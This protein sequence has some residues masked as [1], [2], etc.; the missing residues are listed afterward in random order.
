MNGPVSSVL[1]VDDDE[2]QLSMLSEMIG[3]FG[4]SVEAAV[5]GQDALEKLAA[6]Q[7]GVIVTDLV[8]PRMDGFQFLKTL[9]DND[10]STPAIVLTAFGNVTHAVSVVHDLGAF[11]FLE[12]PVQPA[13]LGALLDRAI[14]YNAALKEKE[15]LQRELSQQG[16]LGELVGSSES[17]RQVYTLIQ[18]V[19]P[20]HASVLITGE[21]GTGKEIAARTIH[22]LSRRASFP[23]VA[24]NCAALPEE[25]IESELFGHE[26]GAFT[27]A[28]GRHI[29]CFEQA[30]E[31]TLL[32]DEIGEMPA[33]MQA[34]LLRALEESKVRRL[35][36]TAEIPVNVRVLA[37]TNRNVEEEVTRKT[38]REDLYYRLNVFHL[39]LPPLR[40]RKDDICQLTN[41]MIADL[42]RK[43]ECKVTGFEAATLE[44]LSAHNWPGNVRELRNVLEFAV[45]TAREGSVMPHHLPKSVRAQLSLNKAISP[46][47]NGAPFPVGRT[48]E[49]VERDYILQTL[50]ATKDK[51]KTAELL[52]ISLRT[53]YNRLAAVPQKKS[54]GSAAP[55][56]EF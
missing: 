19:A 55:G 22:N 49:E 43:H 51:K 27:G 56:S 33:S 23:F 39:H 28:T 10:E 38:L 9:A 44:I 3:S 13:A 34:R 54:V 12:K 36:G 48:L 20:V 24:I 18:R 40:E 50:Q 52:G 15:R 45:I 11:W 37:A 29:G 2:Q 31:G 1:V 21:S 7:F 4:Y 46:E 8:M 41:V 6:A 16:T 25:L 14:R 30:N 32:L 17:M 26:K 35:G 47:S 5:D 42:N 53:L